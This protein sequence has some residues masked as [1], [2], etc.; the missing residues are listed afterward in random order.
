MREVTRTGYGH[1][2][3]YNYR[4]NDD[5]FE[6]DVNVYP[7]FDSICTEGEDSD[8]PVLT[9]F[10]SVMS[11]IRLVSTE[12]LP[13]VTTTKNSPEYSSSVPMCVSDGNKGQGPAAAPEQSVEEMFSASSMN[14]SNDSPV[15]SAANTKTTK[16]TSEEGSQQEHLALGNSNSSNSSSEED[17]RDDGRDSGLEGL[18]TTEAGSGYN[19]TSSS[20]RSSSEGDSEDGSHSFEAIAFH[21]R[22]SR[23]KKLEANCAV[24]AEVSFCNI[25]PLLNVDGWDCNRMFLHHFKELHSLR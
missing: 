22:R 14:T 5:V 16:T 21:D 3:I 20:P 4:K 1:M 10:A 6:V 23:A 13:F 25:Y 2:R 15:L 8:K 17:N 9:H 18:E 7:V 19:S 12:L 11:D 24:A